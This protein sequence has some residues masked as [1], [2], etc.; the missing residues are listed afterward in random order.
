ME[1]IK[2]MILFL[3]DRLGITQMVITNL[4]T[5]AGAAFVARMVN[6]TDNDLDNLAVR[7]FAVKLLENLDKE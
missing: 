6:R 3:A 5:D 2:E 7:R 1:K 4:I